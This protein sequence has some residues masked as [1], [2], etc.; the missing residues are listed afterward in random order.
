MEAPLEAVGSQRHI[1]QSHMKIAIKICST[2]KGDSASKSLRTLREN[3]PP[4]VR[5]NKCGKKV[6]TEEQSRPGREASDS[7]E[8]AMFAP[9]SALHFSRE[10]VKCLATETQVPTATQAALFIF[11]SSGWRLRLSNHNCSTSYIL[12]CI[13]LASF[14][15]CIISVASWAHIDF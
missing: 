5:T 2:R 6:K 15:G 1:K 12:L 4:A 7:I 9:V 13:I 3:F 14:F 10:R 11:I 8:A